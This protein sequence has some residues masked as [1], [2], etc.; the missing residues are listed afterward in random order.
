[1]CQFLPSLFN[2]KKDNFLDLEFRAIK[3]NFP[4][5]KESCISYA[6]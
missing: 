1:M 5:K 4:P 6:V 3:N 2:S